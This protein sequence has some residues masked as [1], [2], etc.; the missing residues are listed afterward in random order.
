[1]N[2]KNKMIDPKVA[3]Q[4][5]KDYDQ[6]I[7]DIEAG[8]KPEPGPGFLRSHYHNQFLVARG[9]RIASEISA[10]RGLQQLLATVGRGDFER[11]LAEEEAKNSTGEP[12]ADTNVVERTEGPAAGQ[13]TDDFGS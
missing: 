2:R 11:E 6:L 4:W 10:E 7:E 8:R 13:G 1:M 5:R 9:R 3:A 12:S